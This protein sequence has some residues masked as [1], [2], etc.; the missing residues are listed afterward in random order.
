MLMRLIDV[1]KL[2]LFFISL[3]NND[4]GSLAFL[5]EMEQNQI[6]L[7]INRLLKSGM[8]I[9][10][11]DGSLSLTNKGLLEATRVSSKELEVTYVN[12]WNKPFFKYHCDLKKDVLFLPFLSF[13]TRE[14]R[15]ND[16][17]YKLYEIKVNLSNIDI[18]ILEAIENLLYEDTFEGSGSFWIIKSKENNFC[19]HGIE[20]FI[21]AK[22]ELNYKQSHFKIAYSES[23]FIFLVMGNISHDKINNLK[24]KVYLSNYGQV[25]YID[26]IEYL[27]IKLKPF[28]NFIGLNKLPFG[29]ETI[30]QEIRL[31][32]FN[33]NFRNRP[34]LPIIKGK[35][36]FEEKFTGSSKSRHPLIIAIDPENIGLSFLNKVSPWF[37]S[38]SGGFLEED[39]KLKRKFILSWIENYNLPDVL[40]FSVILRP[41]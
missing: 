27:N 33:K 39:F 24:I 29:K 17:K 28:L 6:D 12:N 38:C 34:F 14:N 7:I 37:V 4:K 19:G 18:E 10:N 1:D 30:I 16:F 9:E 2:T 36:Y 26:H 25:P 21:L 31:Q 5:F 40:V 41:F 3:G 35:F 13:D 11:K 23:M 8:I 20:N 15:I 22:D 32:K